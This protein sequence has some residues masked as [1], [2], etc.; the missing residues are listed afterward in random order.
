MIKY[1]FLLF[2]TCLVLLFSCNKN[3]E[4]YFG[5]WLMTTPYE[6]TNQ[7]EKLI[8]TKDSVFIAS[9]PFHSFYSE[10]L[11]LGQKKIE[12][13]NKSFDLKLNNDSLLTFNNSTYIK[14]G[15]VLFDYFNNKNLISIEYPKIENVR[16]VQFRGYP[17]IN[18]GKEINS[19][20]YSLQLND[21]IANLKDLRSF[22]FPGHHDF[23]LG[24]SLYADKNSRMKDINNIFYEIKSV[25]IRTIKLINDVN[26]YYEDN[27]MI[28]TSEE[29]VFIYLT[30]FEEEIFIK[31][32]SEPMRIP[33]P[34][35][36]PS[37]KTIIDNLNYNIIS[38]VKN[39]LFLGLGKVS[40]NNLTDAAKE[41][42]LNKYFIILYDEESK[43][44]NYLELINI[45][46]NAFLDIRNNEALKIYGKP[47]DS[48]SREKKN[49]IV[50]RT[51]KHIINGISFKD[52]K[53]L[54]I[55]IPELE[56]ID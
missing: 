10:S 19:D 3:K 36:S 26:Y 23:I 20:S 34:P 13:F 44:K 21:R 55:K 4:K 24:V 28:L 1:R 22:L 6:P 56:L 33:L 17:K 2:S 11:K 8:I 52:F 15:Y 29:G 42:F 30:D 38:L 48:L 18:F 54:N 51:P 35:D 39:E 50:I 25:N 32:E 16:E 12:L 14:K 53:K 47:M 41:N 31:R 43:Y 49:I 9:Y 7:A 37:L 40:K 46:N 45:Y 5:E 27:N